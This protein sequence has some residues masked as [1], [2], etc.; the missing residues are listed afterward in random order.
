MIFSFTFKMTV[1]TTGLRSDMREIMLQNNFYVQC[2]RHSSFIPKLLNTNFLNGLNQSNKCHKS[3]FHRLIA[4]ILHYT[5]EKL[6]L[7]RCNFSNL[8][9]LVRITKQNQVMSTAFCY[10]NDVLHPH[11]LVVGRSVQISIYRLT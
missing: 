4:C 1:D 3:F 11:V 10:M 8:T 6:R 5:N 2:W 9:S 7:Q